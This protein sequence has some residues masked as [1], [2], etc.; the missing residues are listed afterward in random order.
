M[1]NR[2]N[3]SVYDLVARAG[4]KI[5]HIPVAEVETF[6]QCAE[7]LIVCGL[8][9]ALAA[10][11][12]LDLAAER[13]VEIGANHPV[14]C[15]ATF[16]LH[17]RFGMRGVLVE[18]NPELLPEL[19]RFRPHDRVLHLA[20]SPDGRPTADFYVSNQDELSSLDRRFVEEWRAGTV[21]LRESILVPA[22]SLPALLER[23]FADHA[24][25]FLSIDVEGLDLAILR[26]MD[27][28]RWR[29]A[30]VQTEPSEHHLPG[31]AAALVSL[32]EGAGYAVVARTDVNLIAV[33]AARVGL[34]SD[35]LSSGVAA[36]R[37]SVL[38]QRGTIASLERE[39]EA[40]RQEMAE[41]IVA[42]ERDR[43]NLVETLERNYGRQLAQFEQDRDLRISMI[44]Q[45]R[46]TR[47]AEFLR[48]SETESQAATAL[49][50]EVAQAQH[51]ASEVSDLLAAFRT[52]LHQQEQQLVGA[53]AEV[54][55]LQAAQRTFDARRAALESEALSLRHTIEALHRS[56]SWRMTAPLRA[57]A[58]RLRRDC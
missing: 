8:L 11:E 54:E 33:D 35:R 6:G 43:D 17:R 53:L 19:R 52:V 32:L 28:N 49:R 16:L 21:G 55:R 31:N 10:R 41:R 15:S 57:L 42:V 13:Y 26:T 18:A 45:D 9:L 7:D 51:K 23:E 48:R 14:S 12:G 3:M 38:E 4:L 58:R 24:P 29:P 1:S 30:V 56:T 36:L 37:A 46:D 5:P 20:I 47:I 39:L 2:L 22:L 27:W 50:L 34:A 25:L 44:E 40:T